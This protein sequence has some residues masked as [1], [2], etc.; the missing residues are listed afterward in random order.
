MR[1]NRLEITSFRN[2]E[3]TVIDFSD[4]DFAIFRGGNFQ[5]KS[6]IA[7]AISMLMTPSTDGLNTK[8]DGYIVKVKRGATKA[9]ITGDIQGKNKIVQRTVVLN[10]NTT[11]RT[12]SSR[13]L[14]DPEW[15]PAPFEKILDASRAALSVALNTN[16][17]QKMD[18][19]GQKEL[20]AKL[21]LP[22]H[23]DFPPEIIAAVE[24]A[25]GEGAINFN[26]EPFAVI[27]K[28]YKKLYDERQAVNRQVKDFVVPDPLPMTAGVNSAS[29]QE[30]LSAA[31]DARQRILNEKDAAVKKSS[32]S[33]NERTR[34]QTK[35]DGILG[36]IAEEKAKVERIQ[37]LTETKVKELTKIAEE[38]THWDE[39]IAARNELLVKIK[40]YKHQSEH[41]SQETDE[42]RDCPTC[43][44]LIT[45]VYIAE[46]KKYY[47][48]VYKD[49]VRDD[50]EIMQELKT[51][52]NVDGAI[53]DLAAHEKAN[54][55]IK[56]INKVITE[57]ENLA[58]L[59]KEKLASMGAKVDAA[60]QFEEPLIAA[61][62]EIAAITEQL[63]PVISAEERTKE[64]A[65]KTAQLEKL[66]VKAAS[67]DYLVKYFDKDGIKAK[68]L[69]EHIGA[70]QD[71][72]NE[73][74]LAFNY[75][76]VLSIEPYQF[77]VTNA[78]EDTNPVS[79]L[80]GAEERI[81]AAAFQCAVSRAS[82]IGIA[83]IDEV[84]RLQ[85]EI[86]PILN[87]ALYMLVQKGL[88]EQ[89]IL[90]VA[91]SNK[92]VPTLPNSKFFFV[93]SGSVY[94]LGKA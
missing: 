30:K 22:S 40:D 21:V 38:K 8:G 46:T 67:V 77:L 26:D 25:I 70:F 54:N 43:G 59:G 41:W 14:S 23:Y 11:G 45:K 32:D 88:M 69:Q 93:E 19:K 52:G 27:A 68:L 73:V 50:D 86:R 90:I 55:D 1:I 60:A 29:L 56:E 79:E 17:F 42:Q 4:V 49:A 51:L 2:H 61:D 71:K 57:K 87:K 33:E 85:P 76:C 35:L 91:D 37:V 66:K 75:V 3:H 89:I 81:F 82:G 18:E 53:A 34:V 63:R 5:G 47:E 62:N 72:I 64:I 94:E 44:Q 92:E 80:S 83:V 39:L 15:H 7:Q 6:S 78:K 24:K 20:M 65:T 28:A 16:A 10:S 84:D 9:V 36:Q 48:K 12:D 74:M 58:K 31:R 13:C